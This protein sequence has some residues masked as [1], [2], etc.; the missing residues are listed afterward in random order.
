[1]VTSTVESGRT[2]RRRTRLT[3]VAAATLAATA[4]WVIAVPLLGVETTVDG[5][6][7]DT[8]SVTIGQVIVMALAASLAGW[9]ALAVLERSTR[10]AGRV[11]ATTASVV[12]VGSLAAPATAATSTAGAVTL[13]ALHLVVGAVLIP[14]LTRS[15]R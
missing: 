6:D 11:W 15:A 13:V 9:G 7:G 3:A 12:L 8:M 10:R 2:T 14:T 5:W 4:T 1:M